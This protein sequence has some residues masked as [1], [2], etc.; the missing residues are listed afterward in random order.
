MIWGVYGKTA[1]AQ[2]RAESLH[3][4][5]GGEHTAGRFRITSCGRAV[6]ACLA[7]KSDRRRD[8]EDH[9]GHGD[10]ER[11]CA[12]WQGEIYNRVELLQ[13]L[14][15]ALPT[16]R[17]MSSHEAFVK[18]YAVYG[19]SC[20][21][22]L[23]GYFVFAVYDSE[24]QELV[25]G[26]DR[27]GIATLYYYETPQLWVFSS[28]IAPILAHPDVR[29]ELNPDA[30]R[31]FLVF[32]YNPAWD[33]LFRG[34][35][36]VRPARLMVLG[37]HGLTETPYWHLSFRQA[38][39]QKITDYCR[40]LR[41]L[42]RDAIRIRA[43]PAE[44]LGMFVSGG[45]D[46]SSIA[47]L[48]STVLDRPFK[49]FTYRCLGK[50]FDEAAY[51][52]IMAQHCGSDHH[53]VVYNPADLCQ[54]ASVVSL[55][56]EPFCDVG[57]N[58]ATFLLAQTAQGK[59]A[60][61]FS[62]DGGDELFG[63]HPVYTADKLAAAFERLPRG[64]RVPITALLRRL[65]DSDH[66]KNLTVKL[67][68]FSQ[69]LSYARELGTHRWR[70]YYG[71]DDLDTLLHP[72]HPGH[73][74]HAA[75]TFADIMA[76]MH[77]A[78]G[79]NPLSRS[80]YVDYHTVLGFSLRRMDFLRHFQ[81][82]PSFPLLDHR[83]VEYAA[84]I[85]AHLKLRRLSDAKYIQ[86]RA[87]AGV[88]PDDIVHRKDKLGH[89]IPFKNW[90]RD[91]PAVKQFVQDVIPEQRLKERGMN[92]AYVQTLWEDHQQRRQNHSHRLWGLTV[93]ELWLS[94]NNL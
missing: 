24:S 13:S 6:F 73:S 91:A 76:L 67:Q 47:G 40:N 64:V 57:I 28:R 43:R 48:A 34:I 52:R 22:K 56:D 45:M 88:L 18:L 75:A 15:V 94:A 3:R 20:V 14:G 38:H 61:V 68:R 16:A 2:L 32:N 92:S 23:N 21:E 81:L 79:P 83:L 36:K 4:R 8:R 53:E 85:P 33:T 80:L 54:M 39:D 82:T 74:N 69:S 49:T 70:M 7:S 25:L 10:P 1:G 29:K 90:L 5:L 71:D 77:E 66:K 87:M 42:L 46:S 59:V 93:L 55:M 50:S 31:R 72:D 44:P 9:L 37:R 35:N 62:G 63:G 12:V 84:A 11:L 65:P 78:D 19:P 17:Q 27:L 51:A 26:R 89:S 41:E 86:R 30:L 60:R 58:M